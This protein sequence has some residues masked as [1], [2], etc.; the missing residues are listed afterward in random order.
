MIF[1]EARWGISLVPV[2][3]GRCRCCLNVLVC[4]C[5]LRIRPKAALQRFFEES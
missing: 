2:D 5:R 4:E 1:E 3:T